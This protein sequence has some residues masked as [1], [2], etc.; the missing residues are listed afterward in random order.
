[1]SGIPREHGRLTTPGAQIYYE[2]IG[3]GDTVVLCHGL[4]GNAAVWFQQVPVLAKDHRVIVWDQRGF[5][6][7]TNDSERADP[8]AAV[9]D[10]ALLLDHLDVPKA[11]VV[12]QSMG[13]WAAL[14]LALQEPER[15]RSV[16]LSATSGGLPLTG[17][18]RLSER[19]D[20]AGAP[21]LLG[22][23]PALNAS[24]SGRHPHLG[25]LYQSL[26]TFSHA[27]DTHALVRSFEQVVPNT[28]DTVALRCPV[29]V[30]AGEHDPIFR[31]AELRR[32]TAALRD[33]RVVELPGCGHSPYFEDPAAWNQHV[34]AFLRE[35]RE[36]A[37][38]AAHTPAPS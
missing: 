22:Q 32:A 24:F 30:I 35:Q 4:G 21:A 14:G 9:H 18:L 5:G 11:H 19:I 13:G 1:M 29:L 37:A 27:R 20:A 2:V 6:R 12:G 3:A 17:G 25:Y 31:P 23:H 15:V 28:Q 26:G 10:L 16:I 7:S 36:R 33:V 34:L 8:S 38:D